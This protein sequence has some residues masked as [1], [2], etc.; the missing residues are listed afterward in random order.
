MY[1]ILI[2]LII[3]LVSYGLTKLADKLKVPTV[4]ALI[5]CGL[6][7]DI[8]FLNTTFIGDNLHTLFT[9]GDVSLLF[10]M[11]LAGLESSGK[12]LYEERKEAFL[13]ASFASFLPFATGLIVFRL[14]GFPL[15]ISALVGICICVSAEATIAGVLI[16]K[17][18]LKSKIGSVMIGAGIIDDIIGLVLFIIATYFLRSGYLKDDI[19][20]AAVILSFFLGLLFQKFMGDHH[21]IPKIEKVLFLSVIPFFFV[22]VGLRFQFSSLILHPWVLLLVL[23]IAFFGKLIGSL[24]TKPFTSFS[25]K[26]LYLIGW[27]MNSRGAVEMALALIAFKTAILPVELF[28]SL[29]LVALITTIIFPFVVTRM[30]DKNP[31]IMGE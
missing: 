31:G 7:F 26:Q 8:P 6:L 16:E 1:L 15:L 25:W 4:I 17:N 18:Q 19:L 21:L 28:S 10:F 29:I 3:L 5:G 24:L 20:M 13:I 11:F 22:A 30:M 27:A 14:L 12:N 2:A 9:L 23:V